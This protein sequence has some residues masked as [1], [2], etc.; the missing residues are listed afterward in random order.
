MTLVSLPPL[1]PRECVTICFCTSPITCTVFLYFLHSVVVTVLS[2]S[3]ICD[4]CT[5]VN[6]KANLQYWLIKESESEYCTINKSIVVCSSV[7]YCHYVAGLVGI[8]LS[9]LFS[10]SQLEDPEVGLDTELA[11]SMGLFL[12]KTNI[13]RD[14]LEDI[15][16]GRA[17]WPEEVGFSKLFIFVLKWCPGHLGGTI[18]LCACS[19]YRHW[20]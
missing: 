20:V 7:Q 11:N 13:I 12:Q 10:A 1:P 19:V 3:V 15:Q 6:A 14:Y 16:Q 4:G 8:G 5:H 9:Q 2:V 18:G 17:F